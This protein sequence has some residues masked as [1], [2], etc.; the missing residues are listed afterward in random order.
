MSNVV[1]PGQIGFS[2]PTIRFRC[3]FIDASPKGGVVMLDT[4][5]S[6]AGTSTNEEGERTS[7]LSRVRTPTADASPLTGLSHSVFGFAEVAQAAA[8]DGWVTFQGRMNDVSVGGTTVEGA[9]L[10]ALASTQLGVATGTSGK[11]IIAIALEDDTANLAD[12][13]ISGIQ[14]YGTD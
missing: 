11:K 7:S 10:V 8:S 14:G 6:D 12:C 1:D 9:G 5:G 3:H 4:D 2:L 13:L